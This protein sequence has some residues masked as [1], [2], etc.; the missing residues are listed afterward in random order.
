V[1]QSCHAIGG[2]RAAQLAAL[3]YLAARVGQW[4]KH[5][6]ILDALDDAR[7]P[8]ATAARHRSSP[9]S[10]GDQLAEVQT[11]IDERFATAATIM[12]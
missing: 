3:L 8:L 7:Q 5:G 4:I 9:H 10:A 11:G 6:F 2:N 12:A 1:L